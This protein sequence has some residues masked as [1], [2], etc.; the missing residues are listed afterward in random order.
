MMLLPL[1]NLHVDQERADG[2]IAMVVLR[3]S[4]ART[5]YLNLMHGRATP[6]QQ[7][8]DWG[9]DGPI[10]GPFGQLGVSPNAAAISKSP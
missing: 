4:H 5:V 1:G 2:K 9:F 7:M 8:N 3:R 6:D 10:L